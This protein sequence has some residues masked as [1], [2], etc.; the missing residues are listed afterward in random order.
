[1][2][3]STISILVFAIFNYSSVQAQTID[4]LIDVGGYKLHFNIF[5]GKGIPILFEAGGGE[6][7]TTWKKIIHPVAERTAA[8]LITYDR[9]GFGNSSFDTT[10]HGIMNGMIGLETGL[11]KLGYDG[12][13]MLV[14]HS[15]GGLYAQLYASRHPDKVKAAVLID[16]TTTCFYNEKRLA[17]TQQMIDHQ[18]TDRLKASNPG[19]YYQGADF[20]NNIERMRK[21]PFPTTI[22]V[23][24]FV[25]D[26]PPFRDSTD[27]NDWKRCHREFAATSSNRSGILASGC[28]HFIFNDNPPL[29]INAI[30][31]AYNTASAHTSYYSPPDPPFPDKTRRNIMLVTECRSAIKG[32]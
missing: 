10:R 29:V 21:F 3:A 20:S 12:N 1:M 15:Q 26:Y 7:A 9:A 5:K 32:E 8:T 30:V 11:K 24:D 14:A 18:N 6:D 19:S 17:A 4:T 22:P 2:K 16:V 28:G 23:T 13:I 31:K 27:I 25:S